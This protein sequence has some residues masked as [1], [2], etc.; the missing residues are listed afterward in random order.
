MLYGFY[1]Y[2]AF[3]APDLDSNA[4]LAARR[5]DFDLDR[6]SEVQG[7]TRLSFVAALGIW[8]ARTGQ[9]GAAT[10][11]RDHLNSRAADSDNRHLTLVSRSLSAHVALAEGDSI[12]ALQRFRALAPTGDRG[13]V[14]WRPWESLGSERLA[15]AQVSFARGEYDEAQRVADHFDSPSVA[16]YLLYLA[17]SLSL[18]LRIARARGDEAAA[19]M[20]EARLRRLGRD[21][22]IGTEEVSRLPQ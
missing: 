8:Y 16:P 15:H 9:V 11:I 5:L 12:G 13:Q 4:M 17:A 2:D 7:E 22:V 3:V 10:A 19:E 20:Y 18:R 14:A 1:L 21:D 6:L